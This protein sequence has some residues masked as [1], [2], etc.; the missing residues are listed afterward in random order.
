MHTIFWAGDS[1]VQTNDYSTYPQTGIGQVFSLF[2]KEEYHVKNYAKNGRSTKSFIDEGRLHKIEEQI[3]KGDFL[4]IQFGHNDEK[5]E[6][7]TRYTEPF[8]SFIEN[9]ELFICVA[10]D[11]GAFPV[12]ITPL[13]RRIFD[14]N[15]CLEP[16]RHED[17][18]VGMRLAAQ[19]CQAPLVDLYQMSRE[20]L[21]QAG[22]Q[23]S[24]KW[25][26][27]FPEGAYAEHPQESRDNTHLRYEGAVLYGSMIARSLQKMGGIYEQIFRK[28]Q[29]R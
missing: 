13:E 21:T 4:F 14:E 23:E 3:G 18:A 25:Y 9:L 17:Y 27:Y 29:L 22:E 6:D 7:L 2:I 11:Q 15:G 8:S 26:M 16:S 19:R 5:I 24:R 28:L 12:L 20:A 1:T 10:R